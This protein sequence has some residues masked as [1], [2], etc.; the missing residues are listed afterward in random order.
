MNQ[1]GFFF[2]IDQFLESSGIDPNKYP[3][4]FNKSGSTFFLKSG[5]TIGLVVRL[6]VVNLSISFEI[7]STSIAIGLP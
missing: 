5:A 6:L 2:D 1:W 7:P 3:T 4:P